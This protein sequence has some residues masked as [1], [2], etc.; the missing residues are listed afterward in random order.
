MAQPMSREVNG[1]AVEQLAEV[2]RQVRSNPSLGDFAF[3]VRNEWD[4]GG[5]N[6]TT[7]EAF[8]GV[9]QEIEHVRRFE[10]EA[11]EPAVLLGEDRG[12][13]P[14]EHLLN[15]LVA[16]LTSAM[17]YHAAA[18]G[19]EIRGIRSRVEGK[20]DVRGFLGI[21]PDITPGFRDITVTFEV[22]S[23]APADKL[24]ECA[25]FSPVYNT[26]LRPPNIELRFEKA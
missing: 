16:C 10:L 8:H 21:A 3:R 13:N 24:R 6:K 25:E 14:V 11:D 5:H 26:L 18:R 12:P 23:D 20:L 4:R 9:D 17:V 1:V 15:A 22:D 19:L 2:I 7:V